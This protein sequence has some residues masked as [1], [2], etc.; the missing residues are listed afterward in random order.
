MEFV[1]EGLDGIDPNYAK[2]MKVHSDMMLMTVDTFLE[3]TKCPQREDILV[4]SCV[5]AE[6]ML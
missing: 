2:N 4:K 5:I 1:I 6:N 3:T